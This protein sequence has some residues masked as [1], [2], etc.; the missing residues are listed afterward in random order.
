[1]RQGGFFDDAK[2]IT[3]DLTHTLK[4]EGADASE[5][6]TGR[7][8]PIV[9]HPTQDPISS[10]DG[11]THAMGAQPTIAVAV[12]NPVIA[13]SCKDNGRD[14][15]EEL[16]QTLRSMAH[17]GS[18]ANGGGQVA[19]GFQDDTTPKTSHESIGAQ[20]ADAGG[21]GACV[22]TRM[23]VRRLTP[24]ECERLQGFPD[25]YTD[26]PWRLHKE[27]KK[28]G[29]SYESLLLSKGIMLREP[30]GEICPDGPRYKAIGNSM[31]VPC[32]A[33]IGN[34]I[35]LVHNKPLCLDE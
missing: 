23:S 13:F 21:Q 34:R 18:H 16:S 28:K 17:S 4:A 29:V 8:T 1:M 10:T 26:I 32:M 11:T 14:C 19:I 35:A 30:A 24:V 7:G 15:T 6:G 20:R 22:S 27:A 3:G 31:A 25:G 12:P 33:W 5:D 2:C 9:F